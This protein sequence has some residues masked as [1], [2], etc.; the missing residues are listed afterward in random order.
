MSSG[1]FACRFI[2]SR[3]CCFVQAALTC[4]GR[5]CAIQGL[6]QWSASPSC[7]PDSRFCGWPRDDPRCNDNTET[8]H[9]T[10]RNQLLALLASAALFANACLAQDVGTVP[11][12]VV[13]YVPTPDSVVAKMLDL[14]KVNSRDVVYDL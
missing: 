12:K 11:G 14:A 10:T 3:R 8:P 1:R 9:M 5:A 2:R 4:S 13:P 6:E 7:S